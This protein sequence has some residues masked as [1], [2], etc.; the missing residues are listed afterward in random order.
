MHLLT[1]PL[2]PAIT[3]LLRIR[4][5]RRFLQ[6][7]P[8]IRSIS[9][10]FD[11]LHRKTERRMEG[12]MAVHDPIAWIVCFESDHDVACVGEQDYVAPRWIDQIEVFGAGRE[13]VYVIL[14]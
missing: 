8:K 3:C 7:R 1:P 9:L 6:R 10:P 5:R 12:D 2:I 13:R 14:L 4:K 11:D